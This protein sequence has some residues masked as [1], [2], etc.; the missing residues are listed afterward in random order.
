M[1]RPHGEGRRAVAAAGAVD[2]RIDGSK[3]PQRRSHK[4]HSNQRECARGEGRNCCC[5]ILRSSAP[6]ACSC[7]A[8]A[9]HQ[10]QQHQ[11]SA[12]ALLATSM[13][14]C[15]CC[16]PVAHAAATLAHLSACLLLLLQHERLQGVRAVWRQHHPQPLSEADLSRLRQQA[17]AM[18]DH[19]FSNYMNHAFPK[20]RHS[21]RNSSSSGSDHR[22]GCWSPA[23]NRTLPLT[24]PHHLASA[25]TAAASCRT[26]CCP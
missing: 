24:P 20:A 14:C 11:P 25:F 13:F 6:P 5:C 1:A 7:L 23:S 22:L 3:Q 9:C 16:R 12:A 4:A 8:P 10:H 17:W 2:P 21:S 15:C 18:F 26:T 19:G